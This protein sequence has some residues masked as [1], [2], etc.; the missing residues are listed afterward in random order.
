M[1][2]N[3]VG[4]AV[5]YGFVPDAP[6]RPVAVFAGAHDGYPAKEND[7]R[8]S[9]SAIDTIRA[10]HSVREY[11]NKPIGGVQ[12]AGLRHAIIEAEQKSGLDI[13]LVRDNPEVFQ[14]VARFG[15]VRGATASIVFCADGKDTDEAIGYWGQ[16]IVLTAQELGLNTCWCALCS[17]KKSKV[18]LRGDKKV[19][20]VI[21]VGLGKTQ[22]STRKTK[23]LSEL[24]TAESGSMASG[25]GEGA[26]ARAL[27]SWFATAMEAAQ[28]APTAMN[29]QNFHITLRAD[30]KTVAVRATKEGT[31]SAID[32]G[33]VRR[34]F[35]EAAN[36]T[37][38]D[39]RW[40]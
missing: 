12:L 27:P 38:A 26:G 32:L 7:E 1:E 16:R 13:Q 23:P 33:I 37:G 40:E 34:N 35:E 24:C 19:R 5:F 9:M 18:V 36:E 31:W 29:A 2:T 25:A 6:I 4:R 30:G 8:T 17:R 15:L 10:R 14:V 28:L 11:L 22:G 20:I 3:R 39:W 21:A